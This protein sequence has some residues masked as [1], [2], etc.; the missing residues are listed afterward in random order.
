M[1]AYRGFLDQQDHS[2]FHCVLAGAIL[3]V[4][5]VKFACSVVTVSVSHNL[6]LPAALSVIEYRST[7]NN[8]KGEEH[9]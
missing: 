9:H 8:I 5:R 3:S 7:H 4:G 6:Y 1:L 2:D